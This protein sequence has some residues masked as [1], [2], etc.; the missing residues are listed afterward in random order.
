MAGIMIEDAVNEDWLHSKRT[1][2]Q[3]KELMAKLKK[4]DEDVRRK[5]IDR[6]SEA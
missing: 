1:K 4:F 3:T 6:V 5:I 2:K